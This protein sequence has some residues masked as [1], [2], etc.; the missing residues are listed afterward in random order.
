M[1]RK[2]LYYLPGMISLLGLPV[3]LLL[4]L[5]E[6]KPS[7]VALKMFLPKDTINNY[8][9]RNYTIND[10]IKNKKITTV[11]LWHFYGPRE[12][13]FLNAKKDFITR[14]IERLQFTNDTNSV[15]KIQFGEEN[16]YGDFVWVV[17][18]AQIYRM[19]RYTFIKNA[20][21]LFADEPPVENSVEFLCGCC[22]ALPV[23]RPTKW[24]IVKM[25]LLHRLVDT[26]YIIKQNY[27]VATAF[28]ALIL[29]P[30]I[31]QIVRF[32]KRSIR[33]DN[34]KPA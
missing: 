33:T 10:A 1:K 16:T 22:P 27:G 18:Q 28:F 34:T 14:E 30:G 21:Y 4:F 25:Q 19:K 17:Y 20:F 6:E 8:S 13:Y 26:G 9:Y 2:K 7:P 5:P 12:D 11:N 3:L 31:I 23:E 29:L 15:L 24:F 32:S